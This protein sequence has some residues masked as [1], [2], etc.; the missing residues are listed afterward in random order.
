M[1]LIRAI[2]DRLRAS[3]EIAAAGL[4]TALPATNDSGTAS[5]AAEGWGPEKRDF[6]RATPV[7]VT[8]GYFGALGMR[9]VSGRLLEDQDTDRVA[10]VV[11]VNATL[12]RTYFGSDDAVGR[13]FRFVGQRGQ[14]SPDAPWITIVGVVSDV[15]EDGL[16]APVRPQIYQCLWQISNLNLAVVA[17]GR[18]GPPSAAAVRNAVQAADPNLPLYA[19]RTGEELL[20]RQLA[21]R[22]FATY[23]I[24][25]FALVAL[26]L[27]AFGL[28]GVIAYGVRQRTHEIGVRIAL[29][30]TAS[31]VIA[32]ILGQAARVTAVGMAIG[33]VGAL[34]ASRLVTTMLFNV[35]ATDPWLLGGVMLI[36]GV[37][38]GCG[39]LGAA[40]RASRI[41]A[42]SALRQE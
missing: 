22:R 21:Q 11:V 30:A 3:S 4:A 25:A 19:V 6:A 23:L 34:L 13:R 17:K 14:I 20:A 32:L 15:A 5:F 41:E 7:S 39:T 2:V 9:L 18:F 8:P 42:A 28:H 37:V 31:R 35:R 40:L 1:V 36:L 27:A 10:R 24:Y 38:V 12:A 29:G 26:F 33:L 16:D